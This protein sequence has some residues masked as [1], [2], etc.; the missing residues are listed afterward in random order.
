M[1]ISQ[2]AI[3]DITKTILNTSFESESEDLSIR[4]SVH[5]SVTK[6]LIQS[7][8]KLLEKEKFFINGFNIYNNKLQKSISMGTFMKNISETNQEGQEAFNS[9]F[10]NF[11][12]AQV[13]GIA[14]AYQNAAGVFIKKGYEEIMKFKA[15]FTDQ[16]LVYDFV[17]IKTQ[18][19]IHLDEETFLD[20][21]SEG[22]YDPYAKKVS[23]GTKIEDTQSHYSFLNHFKARVATLETL[24][25]KRQEQLE[26]TQQTTIEIS[27]L[28]TTVFRKI[29]DYNKFKITD[30]RAFEIYTNIYYNNKNLFNILAN[31]EEMNQSTKISLGKLVNKLMSGGKGDTWS[32]YRVGDVWYKNGKELINI[33]NKIAGSGLV[34]LSTVAN[35]IKRINQ[36]LSSKYVNNP[37]KLKNA[38]IKFFTTQK[39]YRQ[40][41]LNMLK[42]PVTK[43]VGEAITK[44]IEKTFSGYGDRNGIKLNI[45]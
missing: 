14:L 6:S 15:E 38:L 24:L 16:K 33:E 32:F 27:D 37:T 45:N 22:I 36:I 23:L 44:D 19:I 42:D 21:L 5:K 9:A 18:K 31:S 43:A 39:V 26:K 13:K 41:S 34:S 17:D 40:S 1:E 29:T 30:A 8:E 20:T 11:S 4:L 28:N 3:N 12:V 2:E 25:A 35:A 10:A 7:H